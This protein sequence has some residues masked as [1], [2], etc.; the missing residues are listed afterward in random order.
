[1]FAKGELAVAKICSLVYKYQ[2]NCVWRMDATSTSEKRIETNES[3]K[4][5]EDQVG[6]DI[7]HSRAPDVVLYDRTLRPTT[8]WQEFRV[9]F[10][11]AIVVAE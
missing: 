5:D 1:M 6:A 11:Q 10:G 3:N 4:P 2:E 8:A 7:Y 9:P